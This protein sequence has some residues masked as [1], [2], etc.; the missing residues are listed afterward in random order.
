MWILVVPFIAV[1]C[2]SE[3]PTAP[4]L[5]LC[6]E[7]CHCGWVDCILMIIAG[8][9]ISD[10]MLV[11]YTDWPS[12][13]IGDQDCLPILCVGGDLPRTE[14]ISECQPC[15]KQLPKACVAALKSSLKKVA[16]VPQR[17]EPDSTC[18][19]YAILTPWW[20]GKQWRWMFYL[21]KRKM[22]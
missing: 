1:V 4:A 8:G 16:A 3:W 9:F 14:G 21:K 20:W 5:W 15:R 12:D 7:N 11:L 22:W 19:S 13:L 6:M 10:W 2:W 17:I 18:C